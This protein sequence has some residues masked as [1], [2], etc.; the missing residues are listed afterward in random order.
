MIYDKN[1][2]AELFDGKVEHIESRPDDA[3]FKQVGEK[4]LNALE[5]NTDDPRF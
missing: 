2:V 3:M 1:Q 5:L 4:A